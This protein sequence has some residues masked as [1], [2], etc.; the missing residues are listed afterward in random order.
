MSQL[1][2]C[3]MLQNWLSKKRYMYAIDTLRDSMCVSLCLACASFVTRVDLN[4]V[5]ECYADKV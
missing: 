2:D 1:M 5:Y 3:E 4:L